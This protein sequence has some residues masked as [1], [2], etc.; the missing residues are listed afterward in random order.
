M[1]LACI[2]ALTLAIALVAQTSHAQPGAEPVVGDPIAR[3]PT[4]SVSPDD[5]VSFEEANTALLANRFDKAI[6]IFDRI[7]RDSENADLQS[8]ATAMA[9]FARRLKQ[10]KAYIAV[11]AGARGGILASP[12]K[13]G[14][15]ANLV[16]TTTLAAFY[17]S[18]ALV[19]ILGVDDFTPIS[20]TVAAT[21]AAGLGLSL[22]TTRDSAIHPAT[23]SA[24]STG[25]IAGI[26]NGLLVAPILG[27]DLEGDIGD[28]D[29]N[30]NYLL[31][32]LSTMAAGGTAGYLLGKNHRPTEGQVT[33]TSMAG[34]TGFSSAGLLLVMT[35]PESL[36][37]DTVAMLVA[38]GMDAGLAS[39][40]VLSRNI[41][42]SPSRANYVALSQ[43][44]GGLAGFTVG[45]LVVSEPDSD[46]E[47]IYAG[48]I[49]GGI[50]GGL[51]AGIHLTRDMAP[52]A[53]LANQTQVN[54]APLIGENMQGLALGGRF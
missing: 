38:L 49:L 50:W 48:L 6:D 52:D 18:F 45:A 37:G 11:G 3:T 22:Y 8:A 14:G 7:S 30:Q 21:T 13:E 46:D 44:L 12:D 1:R 20:L 29:I 43:F 51:A 4:S 19:D 23:A 17:S 39:G 54:L 5:R 27:I 34:L 53:A 35:Q 2:A 25:L 9:E 36:D 41:D 32:G 40:A 10:S 47:K 26:A 15:R 24:Y 28:G 16:I 31:F 42:W 33:A